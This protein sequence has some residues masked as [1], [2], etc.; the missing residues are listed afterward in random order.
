MNW[1]LLAQL[2]AQYG[3][4]VAE[5]LWS[6]WTTGS[7]PTQADWDNLK[8]MASVNAKAQMTAALVRNGVD[9]NSPQGQALLALVG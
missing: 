4:P 1:L 2:I 6:L 5:K 8:Q 7:V 9:P 3:I